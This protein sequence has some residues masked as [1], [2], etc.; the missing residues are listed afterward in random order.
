MAKQRFSPFP[1]LTESKTLR[2]SKENVLKIW[3]G[4]YFKCIGSKYFGT[5]RLDWVKF[6]KSGQ[7]RFYSSVYSVFVLTRRMPLLF[8]CHAQKMTCTAHLKILLITKEVKKITTSDFAKIMFYT[9]ENNAKMSARS[10][11]NISHHWNGKIKFLWFLPHFSKYR[12]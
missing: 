8:W 4:C 2:K 11:F 5:Y 6:G 9:Q 7:I 10:I 12:Q 1:N 3:I